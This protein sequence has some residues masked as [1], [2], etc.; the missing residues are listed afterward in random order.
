MCF[1]S[2]LYKTATEKID[3]LKTHVHIILNHLT[4]NTLMCQTRNYNFIL[5]RLAKFSAFPL[6]V[7]L[8]ISI[9]FFF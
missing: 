1:N 7:I 2:V 5:E 9:S 4:I 3:K 6:K 8:I